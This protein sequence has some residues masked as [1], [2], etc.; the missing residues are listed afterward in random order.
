MIYSYDYL[1]NCTIVLNS[2]KYSLGLLLS[3]MH[4]FRQAAVVPSA[5]PILISWK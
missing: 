3:S 4:S 5:Y 1:N 2:K